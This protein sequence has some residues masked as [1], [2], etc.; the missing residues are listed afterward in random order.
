MTGDA[1]LFAGLFA[2]LGVAVLERV[3][4]DRFR[5]LTDPPAWYAVLFEPG[6]ASGDESRPSRASVFLEAWLFDAEQCW[7]GEG[8]LVVKA[9]TWTESDAEQREWFLDATAERRDE[10]S[11]LLLRATPGARSERVAQIRRARESELRLREAAR[12]SKRAG[13]KLEETRQ[14]AQA[15]EETARTTGELLA[16]MGHELRTPLQSIIGYSDF[17]LTDITEAGLTQSIED[18]ETV[19][20]AG[21]HLL[22]LINDLLDF[23]KIEAGRLELDPETFDVRAHLDELA[24]LTKPLADRNS[25]R[26]LIDVDPALTE[27]HADEMR[28]RQVLLNL[29]SNACK[30]T[31]KGTI[32]VRALRADDRAR[33]DII[34]NGTGID[35]D[36]I[37]RLF[38]PFRQAH[39][40]IASSHGG[41]GLGLSICKKLTDLM[42]GEIAVESTL[43]QGSTF[44]VSIPVKQT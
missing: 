5:L 9:D 24:R 19:R 23:S 10:R 40:G 18:V 36:T 3:G 1:P 11:L 38:Q 29:V 12:E 21:R 26:L 15:A 22:G 20:T 39:R 8:A 41:T 33:F 7:G 16:S 31:E 32:T 27:L 43:G 4:D 17:L 13:E 6:L 37:E 35:A 28:V 2:H 44:S 34:D 42:G 30:F 14:R 25:N